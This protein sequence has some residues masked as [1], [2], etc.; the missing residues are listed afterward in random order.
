MQFA[1]DA[2]WALGGTSAGK[3][4]HLHDLGVDVSLVTLAAHDDDG[5]RVR[6]ALRRAGLDAD[7]HLADATESHTN[8]MTAAG[9][10]VSLYTSAPVA[11]PESALAAA[12]AAMADA[13]AIVADMSPLGRACLPFAAEAGVPVWV[14]LHDWDGHEDYHRDFL[15]AGSVVVIN[16]DRIG[17]PETF[18][19]ACVARGATL[20]ICT[21]G[22]QGALGID[23]D[24]ALPRVPAEP[25]EVVDTN[26]AGDAFIAGALAATLAGAPTPA[27]LAAGARQATRALSTRQLSPLL[28]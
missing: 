10:R 1:Q 23:A 21:L 24:G 16:G 4:L 13:R 8:L 2:W 20:A 12:R 25:A 17:D 22:A 27:V 18:L 5:A 6:A 26:G 28:D 15:Q 11:V 7:V 14:D 9:D 3:A 19:R